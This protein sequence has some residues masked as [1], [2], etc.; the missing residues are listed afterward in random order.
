[1]SK[2]VLSIDQMKH[3]KELGVDVSKAGAAQTNVW[4]SSDLDQFQKA[5]D[6][7][8]FTESE[9][10]YFE[11]ENPVKK[12]TLQDI[13]DLLPKQIVAASSG[14]TYNLDI[15]YEK[16]YIAYSYTDGNGY[17][18]LNQ[19]FRINDNLIDSAYEMLCWCLENGYIEKRFLSH[20]TKI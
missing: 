10:D 14:Y 6:V 17:V 16:N 11:F 3:L 12:F 15:N 8:V 18:W 2:Q 1:M 5:E 20:E 9:S 4:V 13:L 19:S 7:L